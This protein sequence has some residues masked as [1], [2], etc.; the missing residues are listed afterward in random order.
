MRNKMTV[1]LMQVDRVKEFV[2]AANKFESD[3]DIM[4]GRYI[5]NAKS[6]MGVLSLDLSSAVEVVLHSDNPEEVTYF[7][8]IMAPFETA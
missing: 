6:I 4:M 1:Y 8:N 5:V 2:D 7:N 3:V